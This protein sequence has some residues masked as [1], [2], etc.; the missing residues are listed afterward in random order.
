MTHETHMSQKHIHT[1]HQIFQHPTSHNLQWHDVAALIKESGTVHEEDNGNLSCTLNG[2]SKVFHPTHGKKEITDVKQVLDLRHFLEQA[3]FDKD[4][5]IGHSDHTED[6]G[7]LAAGEQ[8]AH[9]HGSTNA[10]HNR[11]AEETLKT[12]ERQQYDRDTFHGGD[13]QAHQQG[14]KQK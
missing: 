9:D 5:T 6:T 10:E 14:N 8:H 1:F 12:Q 3:G 13:A 4:G 7:D 2:V 11:R